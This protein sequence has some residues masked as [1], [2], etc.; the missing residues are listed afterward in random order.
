MPY[1]RVKTGPNKGKIF[2]IKDQVITI[3]RDENQTIQILDQGVSRQHSEIF[4]IGEMCF[5][6]DLNSTNGSFVNNQKVQEE[7]LKANDELLIGTTILIFEDKAIHED[8]KGGILDGVD[9]EKM[10][11]ATTVELKVDKEK[12]PQKA[13]G[14]EFHSRSL[15]VT[16]ELGKLIRTTRDFPAVLSRSVGLLADTISASHGYLFLNDRGSGKLTSKVAIEKE[17]AGEMKASRTILKRV[18]ASG[19][20]ILTTDATLDDRFALS[21]SVILKKIKSVVCAPIVL[22]DRVEGLLYFHSSRQGESFSVD[23]LELVASG[24]LHLAMAIAA[25]SAGE[26]IRRGLVSTIRALVTAMEIVDPKNQGHAQR[27][28]DY[29]T[30]VAKQMGMGAEEINRIRLASLLHDVGKLAVHHSVVGVTKESIREQHVYSGEKILNQMEGMEEILPGVRYH[31][32]RADGSG[33]PY[34]VKNDQTPPM[35]RIIIVT[36]AFDNGCT[37]G[38]IGGT[39]IPIKDMLKDM[40]QRGGKEFDDDVIKALLLCH[41][42]GTLYSG[43]AG[44]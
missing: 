5:V 19:M 10:P 9:E 35:A 4:R 15:T 20:P 12:Q 8:G 43:V 11:P 29:S 18:L 17:D 36:N 14:R 13:L 16:T 2:E 27:V 28:G 40:A 7:V 23:D 39:G 6:R 41:R 22:E 42:N 37:Y 21:E 30:A 31:H 3:G 34:H 32:E 25:H 26:K 33:F 38:G 44:P 24:A 1:I